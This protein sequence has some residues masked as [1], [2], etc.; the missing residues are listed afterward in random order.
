MNS[1]KHI[2]VRLL[3]SLGMLL[4][5][6]FPLFSQE[7]YDNCTNAVSLCPNDTLVLTNYNAT[8][9]KCNGCEDDYAAKLC[10][11]ATNS[12]WLK[13]NTNDLGGNLQLTIDNIS[14]KSN[15]NQ[16]TVLNVSLVAA[17][18]PCDPATFQVV[19]N[20]V[21]NA[22][23][24]LQI[25]A[26]NVLPNKVYYVVINGGISAGKTIPSEAQMRVYMQGVGVARPIPII[27]ILNHSQA[28][29]YQEKVKLQCALTNCPDSSN[30]EWFINDTLVAVTDTSIFETTQLKQGDVVSVKNACYTLCRTTVVDKTL[31]FTVTSF[32]VDAGK[33]T[34]IHQGEGYQLQGV[35]AGDTYL[36]KPDLGGN[37]TL[38]PT[39][40][41][42]HTTTYSLVSTY[43]GCVL[44]DDV[45]IKVLTKK[46]EAFSSFS[47]NGDNINDTWVVP[48]L[49]D[50]PNCEVKIF[51]R[52]GQ[53]V[54][55]TT[56]YTYK[57]SWDGTYN[58][59]VVDEGVYF[60]VIQLRDSF[61]SEPIQGTVTVVK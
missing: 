28:I 53:P 13:L 22:G 58:G 47:P 30:Y 50:Y 23:A 52:W 24:S 40:Y 39:V 3:G 34:I 10:F 56:G 41:P 5:F 6:V 33:D 61:N 9:T 27:S 20:C 18:L 42:Q 8:S 15:P 4:M 7:I 49:E 31:P 35:S 54:F 25:N 17:S 59:G 60:Y 44:S 12:I 32:H 55:E 37:L 38:K 2:S 14:Y 36:W 43:K 1:I 21:T 48:Y 16:A 29:C 57:K 19:G 51:S 26:A 45:T 46:W 11:S